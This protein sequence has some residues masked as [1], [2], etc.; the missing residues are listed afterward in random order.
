MCGGRLVGRARKKRDV[1]TSTHCEMFA[2][3]EISTNTVDMRVME[4]L[5]KEGVLEGILN[6]IQ[7]KILLLGVFWNRSRS[8][9]C[10]KTDAKALRQVKGVKSSV[11]G[12][13]GRADHAMHYDDCSAREDRWADAQSR[14]LQR[15]GSMIIKI[16]YRI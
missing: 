15:D 13:V 8:Q 1:H 11:A 5:D 6:V 9:R 10:F 14:V 7:N 3:M 2:E 12:E 4:S 16:L